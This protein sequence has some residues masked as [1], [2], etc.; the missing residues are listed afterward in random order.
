ME[1]EKKLN[2]EDMDIDN[3]IPKESWTI[4][5]TL[6]PG[7]VSRWWAVF[8]WKVVKHKMVTS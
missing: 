8:L 2:N 1:F 7:R 4:R 5:I 6:S 3:M